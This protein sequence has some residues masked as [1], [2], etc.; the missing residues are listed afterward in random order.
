M[1]NVQL[2]CENCNKNFERSLSQHKYQ[3]KKDRKSFCSA[4]CGTTYHN[5]NNPKPRTDKAYDVATHSGN[6]HD[7]YTGFREFIRRINNRSKDN[8]KFQC[9]LT[10]Q[11]LKDVWDKQQGTCPYTGLILELPSTKPYTN[12]LAKAS[13][14][15]IDS[16]KG[17]TK[18][19]IQFL[20][21]YINF[22]KSDLTQE[23]FHNLLFLIKE[24]M[25]SD[26]FQ[27]GGAE[28]ESNPLSH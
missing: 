25:Q 24:R 27:N 8:I 16:S 19:N 5:L 2:I 14:D 18:D 9:N 22:M 3:S 23:E 13:L 28:G 4:S 26:C 20:S 7:Q 12:K 17:Y 15:R 6:R 11:D 1:T 21:P 10:L